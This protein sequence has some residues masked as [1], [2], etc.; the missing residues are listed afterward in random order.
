M[1]E[2]KTPDSGAL[3]ERFT[4]LGIVRA[5]VGSIA[6]DASYKQPGYNIEAA[7]LGSG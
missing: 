7:Y 4:E 6:A 1:I 2:G 5:G 3:V